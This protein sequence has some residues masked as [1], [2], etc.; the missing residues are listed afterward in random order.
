MVCGI[1]L[2]QFTH[3]SEGSIVRLVDSMDDFDRSW[4]C[5]LLMLRWFYDAFVLVFTAKGLLLSLLDNL[6]DLSIA[7]STGPGLA[8]RER[9]WVSVLFGFWSHTLVATEKMVLLSAPMDLMRS[10][11]GNER[12]KINTSRNARV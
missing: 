7:G 3:V 9:R 10:I 12:L 2:E 1:F 11:Y 5:L 4:M 6:L 8:R